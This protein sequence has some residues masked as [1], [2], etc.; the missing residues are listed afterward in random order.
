MVEQLS[1]P[2]RSREGLAP[3]PKTALQ[4]L[5]PLLRTALLIWALGAIGFSYTLTQAR[6]TQFAYEHK[7]E[8]RKLVRA[9]AEV[10]DL[11]LRLAERYSPRQVLEEARQAG[12]VPARQVLRVEVAEALLPGQPQLAATGYASRGGADATR[13]TD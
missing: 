4:R 9:S 11:H 13:A 7:Q 8:L 5:R 1:Q 2:R 10:A 3:R 6:A 12:Y